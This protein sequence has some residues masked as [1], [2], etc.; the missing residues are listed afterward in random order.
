M[1]AVQPD[2]VCHGLLQAEQDTLATKQDEQSN[3]KSKQAQKFEVATGAVTT[4]IELVVS[5]ELVEALQHAVLLYKITTLP[6]LCI[7]LQKS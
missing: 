7:S 3:L 1:A 5:D 2:R 4:N 6:E